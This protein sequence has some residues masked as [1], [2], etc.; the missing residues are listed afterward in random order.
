MIE[1]SLNKETHTTEIFDRFRKSSDESLL[2]KN[3]FFCFTDKYGRLNGDLLVCKCTNYPSN[4]P[5]GEY[6]TP[7]LLKQF[8]FRFMFGDFY[9]ELHPHIKQ[10]AVETYEI[11]NAPAVELN[12]IVKFK[13]EYWL[14]AQD[15]RHQVGFGDIYHYGTCVWEG[16]KYGEGQFYLIK[17][18]IIHQ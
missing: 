3:Y 14:K 15:S 4:L 12:S 13:K 16:T 1:I 10:V 9:G 2:I 5:K 7:S 8:P 6:T 18:V 11:M 17:G